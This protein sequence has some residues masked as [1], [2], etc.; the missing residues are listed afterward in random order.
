MLLH[1][2]PPV[3]PVRSRRSGGA[4]FQLLPDDLLTFRKTG[5]IAEDTRRFT[6]ETNRILE[7]WIRDDPAQW[8]W[9]HKRWPDSNMGSIRLYADRHLW[10]KSIKPPE[11]FAEAISGRRNEEA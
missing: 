9:V 3:L 11:L 6:A 10:K 8:L 4:H 2:W 1:V 5:N 7:R